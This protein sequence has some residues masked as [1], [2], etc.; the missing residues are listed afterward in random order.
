[1][2]REL[3]RPFSKQKP[4]FYAG[5]ALALIVAMGLLGAAGT[6][7]AGAVTIKM[8]DTPPK[9]QPEKVSIKAGQSIEWVNNAQTLHSVDA[10]PTM[11]QDP[12][13]VVLPAGAKPF[14]SGFMSPGA[15]YDYTFTTPGTYKYTCVPHEKDGMKG[16]IQVSK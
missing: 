5:V 15:K 10:D 7:R 4:H 1:V 6:A 13:D 8:S 14:D 16:E 2:T 11:V 9:F 12:K 3:D